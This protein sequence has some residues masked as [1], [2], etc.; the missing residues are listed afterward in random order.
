MKMRHTVIPAVYLVAR[1]NNQILL[2][3]RQNTGYCDGLFGLPAGHVEKG[4][5]PTQALIR[6]AQEEVGLTIHEKE[7]QLGVIVARV[8][9][10][11]ECTDYFFT[12]DATDKEITN[13]EPEKCSF[14]QFFD[15]AELPNDLIPYLRY[16]L[17]AIQEGQ[18]YLEYG[19]NPGEV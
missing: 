1:K 11:R 7:L 8:A 5:S 17:R 13:C 14:W 3:K 4:E 2:G 18:R 9:P 6:E 16:A 15:L 19:W 12:Y 10:D